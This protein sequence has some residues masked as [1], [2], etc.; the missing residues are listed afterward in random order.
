M[1]KMG[2]L[3]DYLLP[4]ATPTFP[5]PT[6]DTETGLNFNLLEDILCESQARLCLYMLCPETG[7]CII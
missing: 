4:M 7:G 3:Y 2:E 5:P 1:E 6:R